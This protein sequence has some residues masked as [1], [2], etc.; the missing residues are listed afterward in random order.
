MN[1]TYRFIKDST[2]NARIVIHPLLAESL[3]ISSQKITKLHFGLRYMTVNII[4]T[5]EI[6]EET[7]KLS[8]DIIRKIM[9]PLK[10]RFELRYADNKLQIGPYIGIL[11][12]AKRERLFKKKYILSGYARDYQLIG[13]AIVAFTADSVDRKSRTI[14]G[15]MYN[16]ETKRWVPGRYAYPSSIFNKT[17]T[18]LSKHWR[19]VQSVTKHFQSLLG[20]NIYNYPVFNKWEMYNWLL[21]L[22]Q[23]HEHLPDT[24]K[25]R[26]P[27]DITNML[28]K[29]SSIFVKP[30][31]GRSSKGIFEVSRQRNDFFIQFRRNKQNHELLFTCKI[32]FEKYLK[33]ML[34]S[35]VYIVQQAID[36]IKD[37]DRMIDFRLIVVKDYSEE[38]IDLGLFSRYGA[39]GSIVCNIDA[40]GKADKGETTIKTIFHFTDTEWDDFRQKISSLAI[41]AARSVE[42]HLL[43]CGNLGIDLA[44]DMQK[45]IWIIEI[46]NQNPEHYLAYISGDKCAFYK[47]RLANMQYSKKLTGF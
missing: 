15:Y 47:S 43:N 41:D 33:R 20:R 7:I 12:E 34:S 1:P 25:Y 5:D 10:S 2:V 17:E 26:K 14:K 45:N 38:W 11:A 16:P 36:L 4:K 23:F 27:L 35:G 8:S 6:N 19:M 37:K 29:Y 39:T 46:N 13:G 32:K 18:S 42:K 9:L 22:S 3:G 21:P 30:I 28:E 24:M 31:F 44:I 40:G